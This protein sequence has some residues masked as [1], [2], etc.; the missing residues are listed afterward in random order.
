MFGFFFLPVLSFPSLPLVAVAAV[1]A[2]QLGARFDVPNH[3]GQRRQRATGHI[4]HVGRASGPTRLLDRAQRPL[5]LRDLGQVAVRVGVALERQRATDR[6]DRGRSD[7]SE[8]GQRWSDM[9]RYGQEVRLSDM[10]RISEE[11]KKLFSHFVTLI[12]IIGCSSIDS[13]LCDGCA[14]LRLPVSSSGPK[15]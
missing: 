15:N 9:V 14:N 2:S 7:T 3:L 5:Q 6:R 13:C 11:A 8:C 1:A 10:V 4:Q 12:P